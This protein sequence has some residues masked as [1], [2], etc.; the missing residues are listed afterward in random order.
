MLLDHLN[1]AQPSIKFTMEVKKNRTLSFLDT[2]LLRKGDGSLKIMVYRMPTH[3]DRYLD[4]RTHHPPHV[5]RGLVRCL[6]DRAQCVTST[7]SLEEILAEQV[8]GHLTPTHTA[9]LEEC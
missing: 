6:Y 4:L 9:A 5:K 3:M 7:S 2:V 8:I 1:S